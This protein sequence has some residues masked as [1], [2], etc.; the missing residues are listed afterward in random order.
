MFSLFADIQAATSDGRYLISSEGQTITFFT[1]RSGERDLKQ[2]ASAIANVQPGNIPL[3]IAPFADAL[4]PLF[5][6]PERFIFVAPA[7]FAR[8]MPADERLI[9]DDAAL[10]RFINNVE[11]KDHF[12]IIA[13][14]QWQALQVRMIEC[15]RE[16]LTRAAARLKTINHFGRLWPINFTANA[17]IARAC[18]D[19]SVLKAASVPTALV[20]A[21]PSLD[22]HME[23]LKGHNNIWAAD[24][25]LPALLPRGIYPQVVFS[26]DGG[27]AS[28]EHFVAALPALR[29][30][31]VTLVCDMLVNPGVM[32]LPFART[33]TYSNSHP[34]VQQFCETL[35]SDLTEIANPDGDVG[36]LMKAAF[37]KF[38]GDMPVKIFGHDRGHRRK[39][40]HARGTAYFSR[41]YARQT[42]TFNSET[43]MLQL[44]RRYAPV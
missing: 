32:R 19:I 35:R 23:A 41:V 20:M 27:F 17:A 18:E 10:Q 37:A 22:N 40:T 6:H 33:L 39:V 16:I 1:A 2:I 3:I 31:R 36:S 11:P 21:G 7:S 44:S 4:R 8:E 13:P 38:F 28:R 25:A 12:E 34:L 5:L 15:A 24:T 43:Y 42:R 9:A 30:H 29:G 14:A 26:A